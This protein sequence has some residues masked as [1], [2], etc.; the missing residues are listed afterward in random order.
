M[1]FSPALVPCGQFQ[2]IPFVSQSLVR[3]NKVILDISMELLLNTLV[4]LLIRQN[5][6]QVKKPLSGC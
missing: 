3:I 4:S 5:Y 1:V 2:G 6:C